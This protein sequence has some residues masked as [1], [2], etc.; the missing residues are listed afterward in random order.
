M[1]GGPPVADRTTG[2]GGEV[3]DVAD[4]LAD[5]LRRHGPR[6]SERASS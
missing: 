2:S 3:I 5:M 6:Q 4:R 1:P